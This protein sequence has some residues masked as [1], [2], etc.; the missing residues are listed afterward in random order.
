[1]NGAFRSSPRAQ[2]RRDG[3]SVV[4][5]RLVVD[6]LL[7]RLGVHAELLQTSPY[8]HIGNPLHAL[9]DDEKDLVQRAAREV[10]MRFASR[11]SEGRRLEGERL[12]ELTRGD[13]WLGDEAVR[14]G[15]ADEL[16]DIER[17]LERAAHFA[18]IDRDAQVWDI[19]P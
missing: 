14:L 10:H 15:L 18:G 6:Q 17:A 19:R 1:M 12:D 4:A 11:V 2:P 13:I 9:T 5:G 8:A 3:V 7:E 16:G